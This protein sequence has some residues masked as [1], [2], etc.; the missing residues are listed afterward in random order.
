VVAL[1]TFVVVH[2][3]LEGDTRAMIEEGVFLSE[4]GWLQYLRRP[5]PH[6]TSTHPAGAEGS[7]CMCCAIVQVVK[8]KRSDL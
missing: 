2:W 3:R 4:T 5:Q 1:C 7:T 8:G 6:G